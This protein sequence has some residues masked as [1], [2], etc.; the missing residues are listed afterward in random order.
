M[1]RPTASGSCFPCQPAAPMRPKHP[2]PR[3]ASSKTGSRSLRTGSRTKPSGPNW[4]ASSCN[5]IRDSER[6][7]HDAWNARSNATGEFAEM[8]LGLTAIETDNSSIPSP[9]AERFR[10][11]SVHSDP[12]GYSLPSLQTAVRPPTHVLLVARNPLRGRRHPPDGQALTNK[13]DPS[14]SDNIEN[15]PEET[16]GRRAG[17]PVEAMRDQLG[18][19]S[20]MLTF[21]VYSHVGDDRKKAAA[22]IEK[23]AKAPWK[24]EPRNPKP[25]PL[26]DQ[27]VA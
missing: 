20:A 14:A 10:A 3:S 17:V 1:S 23:Y 13:T 5:T 4:I 9:G 16:W 6:L 15:P 7:V 11:P 25:V 27:Q 22:A 8:R 21:D 12:R 19:A 2:R 24:T 26:D 18:H